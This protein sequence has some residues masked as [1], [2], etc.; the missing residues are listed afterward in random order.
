MRSAA[1]AQRYELGQKGAWV[2]RRLFSRNTLG[3]GKALKSRGLD[4]RSIE[5][6]TGVLAFL[7]EP[8]YLELFTGRGRLPDSLWR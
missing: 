7:E 3:L 6:G 1:G 2:S 4:D 8:E 5:L